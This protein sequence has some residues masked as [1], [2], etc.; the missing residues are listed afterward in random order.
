MNLSKTKLQVYS[1]LATAKMRR[2][3]GLFIVE[4]CKSVADT[5]SVFDVEAILRAEGSDFSVEGCRAPLF[6][7]SEEEMKR[8]SNLTTRQEA[9]GVYRI[10]A[11]EEAGSLSVDPEGLYLLLDGVQDPGNLGTILRTCHWFGI[12]TVFASRD[13]VDIYNPKT[14]QATMGSLGRVK[15]VYLD[16][17][18]LIRSNPEMPVYGTLLEGE[19][20]FHAH[21]QR[22]G[23]IVMGNE[24][25]GI[26]ENIRKLID[27][28]IT[29]PP[30]G[31]DH[32]ES[33]N[34]AVATAIT[35]AWFRGK[36]DN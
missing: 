15:M 13:T 19:D 11:E 21:L 16:L 14:V 29:I 27:N 18:E 9:I 12:T 7:L 5:W 33:L 2:K 36:T 34:V 23:F 28:P 26:S 1:N 3:R 25:N 17:A 4:G 24:G 22:R 31:R 35:V 8:V 6:T 10:P 20:L 32:G 30:Y